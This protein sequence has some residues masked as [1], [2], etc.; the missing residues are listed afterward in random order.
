MKKNTKH[1]RLTIDELAQALK[2]TKGFDTSLEIEKVL[3]TLGSNASEAKEI[4][5]TS[6]VKLTEEQ[7]TSIVSIVKTKLHA[8]LPIVNTIDKRLLGGFTIRIHDW[9]LDASVLYHIHVMKD[10]LLT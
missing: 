10:M 9:F 2:E 8:T 6:P 4:V 3:K 7:L 1:T 5:I